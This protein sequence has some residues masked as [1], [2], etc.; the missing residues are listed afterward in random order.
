M[1]QFGRVPEWGSGGRWFE[2]SHSDHVGASYISLALIFFLQKIRVCSC[3]CFSLFAK[4]HVRIVY[5]FASA[6]VTPLAHYQP[7][8]EPLEIPIAIGVSFQYL[9]F[10]AFLSDF[11]GNS[12]EILLDKSLFNIYTYIYKQYNERIIR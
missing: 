8:S 12:N 3:R 1:A 5:S 4:G 6:R 11:W 9:N 2:S 7:F 10:V